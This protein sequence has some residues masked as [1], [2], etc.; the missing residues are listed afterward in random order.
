MHRAVMSKTSLFGRGGL[1][2]LGLAAGLIAGCGL[3]DFR[4]E[5]SNIPSSTTS[6]EVLVF[7]NT[8]T[9]L[10]TPK[11]LEP[12]PVA[13]V[14]S[15]GKLT[16]TLDLV[17]D[18]DKATSVVSVAARDSSNCIV[19][20]GSAD[21]M[22]SPTGLQV[23]VVP[24]ELLPLKPPVTSDRCRPKSDEATLLPVQRRTQGA[25]KSAEYQFLLYGW[26][27]HGTHA[28][29]VKSTAPVLYGGIYNNLPPA[30]ACDP[31][32][33]IGVPTAG[34]VMCKTGCTLDT[35]PIVLGSALI[36]LNV[37]PAEY[38]LPLI[39]PK[40]AVAPYL[41]AFPC[42][43]QLDPNASGNQAYTEGQASY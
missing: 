11:T 17:D 22:G 40:E 27:L 2:L 43:V 28:P 19:A 6:L 1:P 5:L 30:L 4:I 12:L 31:S 24:L 21:S 37:K 41:A 8:A 23:R 13:S 14:P 7:P 36:T 25:Y 34:G 9:T 35:T 10:S 42:S 29:V 33:C 16:F 15:T 3:P 20:V 39:Q 32:A 26:N 18:L 38:T